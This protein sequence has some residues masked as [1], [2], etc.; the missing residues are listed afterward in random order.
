MRLETCVCPGYPG[1][2]D[3]RTVAQPG[4]SGTAL[5]LHPELRQ[6]DAA[7]R[8]AQAPTNLV[9]RFRE[10]QRNRPGEKS[11]EQWFSFL[12]GEDSSHESDPNGSG[13]LTFLRFRWLKPL[14]AVV[15]GYALP[16]ANGA[17]GRKAPSEPARYHDAV[18]VRASGRVS[19]SPNA[20][21]LRPGT[22]GWSGSIHCRRLRSEKYPSIGAIQFATRTPT[23]GGMPVPA[24][25]TICRA[26]SGPPPSQG[27]CVDR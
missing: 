20:I 5:P 11:P 4:P 26:A 27:H 18:G 23:G 9:M 1:N 17:I 15:G 22:F 7:T 25:R 6:G 3:L 16:C 12:V 10:A 8:P 13:S 19:W 14:R 21:I 24:R 2:R